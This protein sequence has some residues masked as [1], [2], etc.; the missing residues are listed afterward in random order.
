MLSWVRDNREL[1]YGVILWNNTHS[2]LQNE[3]IMT[4]WCV[5]ECGL[6][7]RWDNMNF[8]PYDIREGNVTTKREIYIE[9]IYTLG[10]QDIREENVTLRRVTLWTLGCL[11]V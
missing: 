4:T 2:T 5:R 1:V 6:N 11:G 10:F 3:T 8:K 9:H 7:F